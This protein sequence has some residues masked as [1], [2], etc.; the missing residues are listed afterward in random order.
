LIW[1][2]SGPSCSGKSTFIRSHKAIQLTEIVHSPVIFPFQNLNKSITYDRDSFFH[3]NILRPLW[4][5]LKKQ[6]ILYLS[7]LYPNRTFWK[8]FGI[9]K[10]KYSFLYDKWDYKVDLQWVRFLDT[11]SPKKAVVLVANEHILKKRLLERKGREGNR[12]ARGILK[13]V[14]P[15][16][17]WAFVYSVMDLPLIYEFWCKE[18]KRA[19]I[20]YILLDAETYE[21]LHGEVFPHGPNDG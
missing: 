11:G 20:E 19:G 13:R 7:L 6:P 14:Y 15:A 16:K 1:I 12:T 2:V 8:L 4:I 18:L 17:R 3:Y 9:N 10:S 5:L 21:N